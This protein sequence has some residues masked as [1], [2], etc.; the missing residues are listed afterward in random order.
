MKFTQSRTFRYTFTFA[1]IG[2]VVSILIAYVQRNTIAV[3]DRNLP[4]ISLGDHIK[5]KSTK[6]H[7]WFE[8]L[9][10]GDET[11]NFDKDVLSLFISSKQILEGAYNASETELG[12]FERLNDEETDL[13]LKEAIGDIENLTNAAKQR[14][15]FKKQSE[16]NVETDSLGNVIMS[17]T[18]EAAGGKLDQDFDA[19]YEEFQ[20]TMDRLIN[21]VGQRVADDSGFLNNMSWVTILFVIAAFIFICTLIYR[22]CFTNEKLIEDNNIKLSEETTRMEAI[23]GFIEGVSSGNYNIQL[24][25]MSETEGLG[26]TLVTMR[27]KL[28]QNAETDRR[29]N[30]S[31]TGLA[32]VGDIL[33]ASNTSTAELYD[34]IIRFVVKYTG[35]NQGGLFVF[36]EENEA[37]QYLE[38]VACYAFERKKYLTKKVGVGEGLVGQCFVEGER[39][40][41]LDVPEEYITITSGLGGANPSA[42]LLVPM[43]VNEKLYGVIEIASFKKFEDYEIELVEKLAESIASTIATVRTNESTRILLEKTQQQ[44]EEMRA[45]EEEMRQNMEELEATQEEM[46]RKEKHLQNVLD[47]EKAKASISEKNREAIMQLTKD[48]AVQAGNFRQALEII[49]STITKTIGVSRCSVWAY[50]KS[51]HS[52]FNEM[53]HNTQTG[54]F[55]SGTTLSGKDFPGYFRAVLSE[56]IIVANNA[57]THEATREFSDVYLRPLAIE[58][59]LDVPFFEAGKIAGVICCEHQSDQKQWTEADIEFLKSC[60]DIV[61]ILYKTYK[62]NELLQQITSQEEELRQNTE[63]LQATQEHIEKQLDETS[64]LKDQLK[65][66]EDVFGITTILSESDL[67]GNIL[68]VNEKLIEVS[69]YSKEEML[70]KPHNMFRHPDMPKEL[71]KLFWD[72]IKSGKVF[73]GIVKNKAKDGSHYWVD[74]TIV[75]VKDENGVTYKYIGARYHIKDDF[76]AESLYEKQ[77]KRLN[78]PPL[79]KKG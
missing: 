74:A 52:I 27:N 45:Q 2:I 8:E 54:Q 24:T 71:F 36:N 47:E 68:Y 20:E 77:A 22:M 40:Y 19:A 26:A 15:D 23:A 12:K 3:Y 7:L 76:L 51:T 21:H 37:D 72:T 42:L 4:Y 67:F 25:G 56:Q 38:L 16:A 44:T 73:F 39:I 13:I 58:S 61:T 75:P 35:S 11:L 29:R 30:W 14:Y 55:E 31:T 18:G 57:H 53:L 6:A 48:E 32:Q 34:N 70:G 63:E 46:R 43:K 49:T 60:A 78:L 79:P 28:S 66:R 41:L 65:V 69:K 59:M 17:S 33:R 1:I 50:H 64:R 62:T 9:M 5:N 10:A